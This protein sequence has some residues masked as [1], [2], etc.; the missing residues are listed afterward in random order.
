MTD[1]SR[2]ERSPAR[3]AHGLGAAVGAFMVAT[4]G[5]SIAIYLTGDSSL[6]EAGLV[7]SEMGMFEVTSAAAYG[8][9]SAVMSLV[10]GLVGMVTAAGA[11]IIGLAVGAVGIVGA[12]VV[13]LGIITG[14]L[15]LVAGIGVL[16]KR[17]FFPD[18]I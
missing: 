3:I 16:I 2:T 6:A 17:R 9:A 11:A 14:P 5:L 7:P 13:G 1:R 10:M 4:L 18:V 8:I 15:L 12:V